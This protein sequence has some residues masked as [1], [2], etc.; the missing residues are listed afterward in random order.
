MANALM[1]PYW[2]R[3]LAAISAASPLESMSTEDVTELLVLAA[4]CQ[5]VPIKNSEQN[6]QEIIDEMVEKG[7]L[8][9]HRYVRDC[10]EWHS[11]SLTLK[12]RAFMNVLSV[13]SD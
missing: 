4:T 13:E 1:T 5:G 8:Q 7:L 3:I 12:G 10:R 6:T 9:D 11:Y 2:K